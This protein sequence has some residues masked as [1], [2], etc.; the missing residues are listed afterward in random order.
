MGNQNSIGDAESCR[1]VTLDTTLINM[2]EAF[3]VSA[4]GEGHII[5]AIS[6]YVIRFCSP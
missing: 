5:K 6:S 1:G 2:H 3:K 4:E